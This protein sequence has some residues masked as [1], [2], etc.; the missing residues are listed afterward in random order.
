MGGFSQGN[1][2]LVPASY[3]QGV[4]RIILQ[5]QGSINALFRARNIV[6]FP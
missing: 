1:F 4:F 3:M 6:C 2:P 5:L